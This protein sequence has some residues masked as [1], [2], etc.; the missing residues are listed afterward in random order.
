MAAE[1]PL[2]C[3][4]KQLRGLRHNGTTGKSVARRK[5]CQGQSARRDRHRELTASVI[6]GIDQ[7]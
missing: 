2:I 3:G 4:L 1:M 6:A 5:S 7:A